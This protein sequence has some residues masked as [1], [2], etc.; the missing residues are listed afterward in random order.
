[1]R[2]LISRILIGAALG[3]LFVSFAA[4]Q[5]ATSKKTTDVDI[6]LFQTG[7]ATNSTEQNPYGLVAVKRSVEARSPLRGA[8]SALTGKV[9]EKEESQNLFS[10][11]WGIR[12]VSVRLEKG[13][14]YAYFTMPEAA[15]FSGDGAPFIFKAAVE[16]TARQFPTV[17]KVVVCLDGILDF[18]SESEEPAR[19]CGK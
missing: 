6:Y 16:K 10:P 14:A 5:R 17:K 15:R 19:R 7:P 11:V 4:A 1:M 18:G 3:G 9:S 12:F 13:T 2:K 8:L